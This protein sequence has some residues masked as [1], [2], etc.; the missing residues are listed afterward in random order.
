M[1][2][3][4]DE[5]LDDRHRAER[6]FSIAGSIPLRLRASPRTEEND[7]ATLAILPRLPDTRFELMSMAEALEADPAKALYLGKAAN[8][9]NVETLD[10]SHYRIV[11]FSTHGL[12]PGDLD[13]LTQ[14]ALALT[15]PEVAGAKGDGP[16][17]HGEDS[18]AQTRCRLGG[19]VGV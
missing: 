1:R 3:G 15:A 5:P 9:Q 12:V 2:I 11:A 14:P 13:G 19:P 7:A 17:D 4:I 8:E 10:L 16:V 18:R 6:S